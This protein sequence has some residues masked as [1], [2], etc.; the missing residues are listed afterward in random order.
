MRK[1]T[2][3]D[4]MTAD[5]VSV[6]EDTP[7][8]TIVEILADRKVSAVPV[9]DESQHVTGV[10]S[11][12]DLLHKIEFSGDET[13]RHLFERRS[14]R[15]A[16]TKA[17]G[18]LAATLM[19]SPAITIQPDTSLVEAA[20]LMDAEQ[21]KRLPVVDGEGRLVGIVSRRDLLKTHLRADLEI[22]DEVMNDVLLGV[23]WV[24]PAAFE[25]DV[26][27]GVVTLR[28]TLDRR[29]TAGI[30]AHL[31]AGLP[32]VVGVVDQ[33]TWEFDDVA[34]GETGF[35][36]SHPFSSSTQQPQ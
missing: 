25:V 22:R 33:F 35:Y 2:V 21:V 8:R 10:V 5:V 36:R 15:T 28:G 19:T 31:V 14:R 23:L 4:V 16:R 24:D 3:R 27:D 12:A 7:Y 32:G 18:D 9:V 30:A 26:A 34:A 1:W 29:S 17:H 20:K 11:E 13:E 6:R